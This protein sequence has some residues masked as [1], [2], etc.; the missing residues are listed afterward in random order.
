M[1]RNRSGEYNSVVS[2]SHRTAYVI[3]I[4]M[5]SSMREVIDF[6]G[7]ELSKGECEVR[8]SQR[9]MQELYLRASGDGGV[10]D[11]YD[12]ALIS[13]SGRGVLSHLGGA[14]SPF[15]A[16]SSLKEQISRI[17]VT[18]VGRFDTP[19][20]LRNAEPGGVVLEPCGDSPMYEALLWVYELLDEW[21]SRPE[22]L[23]SAVPKVFHMTDGCATDASLNDVVD[24]ARNIMSLGTNDG[25]VLIFNMQLGSRDYGS[26]LLFPTD[27][28]VAEHGNKYLQKLA[29]ASSL[30]PSVYDGVVESV[31][32]EAM[33]QRCRAIAYNASMVEVLEVMDVAL[34]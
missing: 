34:P 10:Q 26:P 1:L 21:C 15:V 20:D 2:S 5:S 7:C 9:I 19:E 16:V 30:L 11:C 14:E 28:E 32:G 31:R 12:I 4:D 8:M 22:N 18:G 3:L 25:D 13:Y 17:A 33:G 23:D 24:I 27:G 6:E 29:M